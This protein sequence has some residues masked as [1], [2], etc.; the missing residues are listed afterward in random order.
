[1]SVPLALR[2]PLAALALAIAVFMAIQ[3][4]AERRLKDGRDT[5]N[6]VLQRGDPRRELAIRELLDVAGVQP[7][8]EALLL[9]ST[10]R[11]SRGEFRRGAALARRAVGREPDNFA[12]WLTLGFA[13]KDVDRRAALDALERAHRLNPRYRVPS[14]G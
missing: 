11:S 2:L 9:A 13:L 14:L 4:S 10:A 5:V 6:E 3:L 1:V 8:T 12:A 7:G